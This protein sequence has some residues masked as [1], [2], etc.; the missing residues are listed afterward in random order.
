MPPAAGLAFPPL[1]WTHADF[2]DHF[3]ANLGIAPGYPRGTY[4]PLDVFMF[5]TGLMLSDASVHNPCI[6]PA[7]S[8]RGA[9]PGPVSV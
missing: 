6:T 4:I 8:L 5:F 9:P 1:P 3:C 2:E 7:G